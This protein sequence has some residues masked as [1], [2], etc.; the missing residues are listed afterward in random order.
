MIDLDRRGGKARYFFRPW[1]ADISDSNENLFCF[2]YGLKEW[3]TFIRRSA[4]EPIQSREMTVQHLNFLD[5]CRGLHIE[6]GGYLIRVGFNTPLRE[7]IFQELSGGHSK[8]TFLGVE[9]DLIFL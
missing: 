9:S 5:T 6:D 2:F 8:S 4:E 3:L 1:N 7:Q